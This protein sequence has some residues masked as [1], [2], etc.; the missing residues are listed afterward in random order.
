MPGVERVSAH[1]Y[2]RT[3]RTARGGQAVVR[4]DFGRVASH[5]EI[6]F[7]AKGVDASESRELEKRVEWLTGRSWQSG[8]AARVLASDAILR[9]LVAARPGLRVPGTWEPFELAVR[10]IL[11]QQISV[12]AAVRLAGKISVRFGDPVAPPFEGFSYMFPR[13]ETL[14]TAPLEEVGLPRSRAAAV[15]ALAHAVCTGQLPFDRTQEVSSESLTAIR[16]IGPWT[17]SY[18]RLR[19]FGILDAFPASDL[20][21]RQML[22]S[23]RAPMSPRQVLCIAESWRPY[24]GLAAVHLWTALSYRL[25]AERKRPPR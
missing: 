22:G 9:P 11:G 3:V 10:A 15:R 5:S 7:A 12:A 23:P 21:I 18:I 17:A 6:T 19:G 2:S 8:P 14:A 20:G 4:L 13:P 1:K 25:E 16:G 24:R